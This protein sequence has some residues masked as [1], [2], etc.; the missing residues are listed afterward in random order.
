LL[1]LSPLRILGESAAK[2]GSGHLAERIPTDGLAPELKRLAD[3]FN[4]MAVQLHDRET[5]LR[6]TNEL[7]LD[8]AS[9]DSLTGIA[10]R[11]AF[12]ERIAAEWNRAGRDNRQLALLTVDVDYF[13]KFNDR[14]GHLVGDACLREVA[15]TLSF[16]ARR[17]GDLVARIGGEEFAVLLPN[18]DLQGA[19]RVAET[20]REQIEQLAVEHCDSPMKVVT[21]SVGVAAARPVKG[22]NFNAL[23][24]W[25]DAALYRAKRA[26]RNQVVLDRPE[27]SLAS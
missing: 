1:V 4:A 7:L 16:S 23:I 19:G 26:G 20:L 8:L 9:K 17:G 14:Y 10:N 24:D 25:A 18:L 13:K 2:L 15:K 6:R 5:D 11:R 27:I 12:D 22:S 3:S 21:V